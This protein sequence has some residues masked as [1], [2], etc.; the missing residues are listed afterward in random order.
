MASPR[1]DIVAEMYRAGDHG[2][3]KISVGD[4]QLCMK[5]GMYFVRGVFFHVLSRRDVAK[6]PPTW[7]NWDDWIPDHELPPS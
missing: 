3:G 5:L 4:G 6:G 1:Y 2:V 7:V